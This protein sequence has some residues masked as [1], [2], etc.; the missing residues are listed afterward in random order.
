MLAGVP[1]HVETDN[2]ENF[3]SDRSFHCFKKQRDKFYELLREWQVQHTIPGWSMH[4]SMATR[5]RELV[6]MAT[7]ITNIFHFAKLFTSQLIKMCLEDP[8]QVTGPHENF[9]LNH[10]KMENPD[11]LKRLEERFTTPSS[12]VGPCPPPQFPGCQEFFRKF[13]LEADSYTFNQHLMDCISARIQELNKFSYLPDQGITSSASFPDKELKDQFL[14]CLQTVQILAKFLGLIKFLPYKQNEKVSEKLKEEIMAGRPKE[15]Y[16]LDILSC[17]WAGYHHKRLVLVV[18]WL[19]EYLS[20]IDSDAVTL[21]YYKSTFR[22]LSSIYRV[23]GTSNVGKFPPCNQFLLLLLI[24]WLFEVL[25]QTPD[26]LNT[27]ESTQLS[28]SSEFTEPPLDHIPIIEQPYLYTACPYLSDA[29][30]LL[31]EASVSSP[32]RKITPVAADV[33]VPSSHNYTTEFNVSQVQIDLERN[34]FHTQ[35]PSLKKSVDFVGNRVASNCIK[36]IDGRLLMANRKQLADRMMGMFQNASTTE[37][38]LG[39]FRK[40]AQDCTDQ[41]CKETLLEADHSAKRFVEKKCKVLIRNMVADDASVQLQQTACSIAVRNSLQKVQRWIH[42]QIPGAFKQELESTLQKCLKLQTTKAGHSTE[43]KMKSEETAGIVSMTPPSVLLQELKDA[44]YA[45]MFSPD[46]SQLSQDLHSLITKTK[47]VLGGRQDLTPTTIS[48][49]GHLLKDLFALTCIIYPHCVTTPPLA[50]KP[51]EQITDKF[52]SVNIS[53]S[54][55]TRS[56]P[57]QYRNGRDTRETSRSKDSQG[58]TEYHTKQCSVKD[59]PYEVSITLNTK[60]RKH[61]LLHEFL[62]LCKEY[63]NFKLSPQNF[64]SARTQYISALG[65]SVTTEFDFCQIYNYMNEIQLIDDDEVT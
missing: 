22:L 32:M 20:M 7:D 40:E 29:R 60:E 30:G 57:V 24:G 52:N 31:S 49:I 43:M 18:P 45:L 8:D 21:D 58:N 12:V 4:A 3:P 65:N 55:G 23:V 51:F 9:L 13:I 42:L 26:L 28:E 14:A 27:L 6:A 25:S 59:C 15:P 16:Q 11:K 1:F 5:I 33:T 63:I 39:G 61:C 41:I 19:V 38:D 34:F 44:V 46:P 10:L 47:T 2:R 37:G 50:I 56:V 62:L 48:A 17:L 35:S 64:I 36:H 53:S 54:G